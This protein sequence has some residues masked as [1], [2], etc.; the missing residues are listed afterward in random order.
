MEKHK[1]NRENTCSLYLSRVRAHTLQEFFLFCCHK[2]HS[3]V[4][5]LLESSA[6]S[7]SLECVLTYVKNSTRWRVPKHFKKG[8]FYLCRQL[9][10]LPILLLFFSACDTCDSKKSKIL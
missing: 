2:C 6:L 10:L 8:D 3:L 4:C 5:N 7:L 1:I 9:D